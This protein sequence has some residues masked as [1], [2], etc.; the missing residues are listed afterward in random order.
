MI[1]I[2]VLEPA[3]DVLQIYHVYGIIIITNKIVEGYENG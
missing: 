1:A 2:F 3:K